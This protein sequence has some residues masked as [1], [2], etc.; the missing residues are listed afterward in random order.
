M[1]KRKRG[2]MG[3]YLLLAPVVATLLV[4]TTWTLAGQAKGFSA[5]PNA[6]AVRRVADAVAVWQVSHLDDLSYVTRLP[7]HAEFSRGWVQASLYIGLERWARVARSD[8]LSAK[9]LAW[10]EAN[11][12]RLGDRLMHADDH[13][14]A[15]VYLAL[16]RDG[17]AGDEALTSVRAYFDAIL[18]APPTVALDFVPTYPDASCTARWCWS[19][20][21]F[22]GPPAWAQL[23]AVTGDPRYR[24]YADREFRAAADYLF[25]KDAGLFFRDSRFF[26][27][28]GQFGEKLFWSRGN[29]WAYAGILHMLDALPRDDSARIFY[30]RL[31]MRMS[32]ALLRAQAKDGF[33]RSSMLALRSQPEASGTAFVVYGMQRG[34]ALGLLDGQTYR[35]AIL[36]AWSALVG[37]VSPE[38][39]LGRVQQIGDA[40]DEVRPES[41]Q[42]Y[43]AGGFLLAASAIYEDAMT[44]R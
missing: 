27:Q 25:D 28:H 17:L 42:L 10:A 21:L 40:P 13:A 23:S 7:E 20:A 5:A 9:V 36:R 12:F 30:Q 39:R 16:R 29:G 6:G 35:P 26:G 15:Q 38:G 44:R 37:A 32:A 1:T 14:V 24:D 3:H 11:D 43:G 33:W 2:V 19:D 4:V 31:F 8:A 22:M 41:T 18:A 34:V